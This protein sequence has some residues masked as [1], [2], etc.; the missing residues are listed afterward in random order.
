MSE[1]EPTTAEATRDGQYAICA[2][3]GRMLALTRLE[4]GHAIATRIV[5]Q[6]EVIREVA[7]ALEQVWNRSPVIA[8]L[9]PQ[10]ETALRKAGRL[11]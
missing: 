1:I 2:K 5:E 11:P 8:T 3:D 10:V 9:W 4:D 6:A 7:D